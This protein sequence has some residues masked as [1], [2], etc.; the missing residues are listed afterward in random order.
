MHYLPRNGSNSGVLLVNLLSCTHEYN[1]Y[2]VK[3][4]YAD[5]LQFPENELILTH[6]VFH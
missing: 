4:L 2:E 5:Y 6:I 3:L 1:L